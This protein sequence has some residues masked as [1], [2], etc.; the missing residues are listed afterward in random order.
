MVL[1]MYRGY[2]HKKVHGTGAKRTTGN[3]GIVTGCAFANGI[4]TSFLEPM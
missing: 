3:D 1:D 2:R 4:I